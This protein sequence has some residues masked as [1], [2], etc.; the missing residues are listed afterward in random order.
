MQL[1]MKY[2]YTIFLSFLVMQGMSQ[3]APD[4]YFVQFSDKNNSPYEIT[5]PSG[6]LSQRALLRRQNQQISIVENDLPVNPQYLAGVAQTG[7]TLL[8]PTKWLNGV[9]VQTTSQTALDAI[10][11]LPYV[12]S[13]RQLIDQPLKQEI[14][15]KVFFA[16]ELVGDQYSPALQAYPKQTT[17]FDY[18]NGFTQINQI[19]GIPL[20]DAGYRGQGMMIAILDGGFTDTE[21][22]VAFD[23]LWINN[24]IL[25]TK[26]FVHPGGSVFTESSHGTSVLSTIGANVPGQ[27]IG[28]APK[29]MFWLLRSEYVLSEHLVEEYNWVSAAE[30]ADSVGVDIINSSLGY[31]D[32][33][34]PQWNHTYEHMNGITAVVTRGAD[35]AT[36]KG[37]LVVNSAGNSGGNSGFPYIGA[38]A[39]GF[40]VFSIGAVKGDGTRAS[41]SSIGPTFDGR[42][43]PDIMAM[44]QGTALANGNNNFTFGNG[45]SFS[46]PVIA[47]MSACLWQANPSFTNLT[48]KE[49]IKMSSDN[50]LQPDVTY[51]YGIPD[52]FQ[53]NSFLT[54]IDT[55]LQKEVKLLQVSPNPF[56]TVN[57]IQFFTNSECNIR[58]YDVHAQMIHEIQLNGYASAQLSQLLNSLRAGFYN[59]EVTSEEKIQILKVIKI[60]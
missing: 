23:S 36:S 1:N 27:L 57:N 8:F 18:G 10:S 22:H 5:N 44:G 56:V 60:N 35:L 54:S 34:F 40:N 26:D 48:V 43:K 39:D 41:F 53:A 15:N 47:G 9:T 32:F 12:V 20:H 42:I 59:I 17:V 31:I 13:L 58:I 14:K 2:F 4:T 50:S 6:F 28:T 25:G 21:T 3:I 37:I 49:A 7:A 19:N 16:E 33:D 45:T 30:F 52:F 24:Q 38:P 46:S 55:G 51:G 29:A 11:A